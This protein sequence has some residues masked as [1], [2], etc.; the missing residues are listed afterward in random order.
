[1]RINGS[2]AMD[3]CRTK[4]LDEVILTNNIP[5][6]YSRELSMTNDIPKA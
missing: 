1:M 3:T 2:R 5:K 6:R 4:V